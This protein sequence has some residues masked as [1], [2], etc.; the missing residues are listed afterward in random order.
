[1]TA[2]AT[3]T[4]PALPPKIPARRDAEEDLAGLIRAAAQGDQAA[5]S[6]F[7]D[8][9]NRPV[10]SL[11]LRVLG[12]HGAAEEVTLDVYLQ[13]WRQ[14]GGYNPDRGTPIAWLMMMARS[15]A[16]DRLRSASYTRRETESLEDAFAIAAGGED[17][18]EASLLAERRRMVRAALATLSPE[19]REV[20]EIAYFSGLS[21]SE[22]AEKL[23]LPLGTVKTRIRCGL[24][25]LRQCLLP[26]LSAPQPSTA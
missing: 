3:A 15:R 25:K 21:Q 23:G 13:V 11:V 6:R 24:Q 14:A 19:Q 12:D 7:Y 20:I 4:I 16:I 10:F 2:A 22:I 8:L 18:E 5:F 26:A 9:T 17:P 1:M